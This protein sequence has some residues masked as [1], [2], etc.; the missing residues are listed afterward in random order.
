M[1]ESFAAC[2]DFC[3]NPYQWEVE[4]YSRQ[5]AKTLSDGQAR[6]PERKRGIPKTFLSSFEMT[7][8]FPSRL[9]AF[10]RMLIRSLRSLWLNPSSEQGAAYR[11]ERKDYKVLSIIL[12]VTQRE[13]GYS[14]R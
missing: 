9:C 12:Y 1:V 10:A 5:V 2:A 3:G 11:R 8:G 4:S 14:S 7:I 6:H 13:F